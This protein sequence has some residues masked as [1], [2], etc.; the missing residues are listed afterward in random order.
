MP[1]QKSE[2]VVMWYVVLWNLWVKLV[3]ACLRLAYPPEPFH[4]MTWEI[5]NGKLRINGYDY[6][7][8]RRYDS[9]WLVEE[10]CE[11]MMKAIL[12]SGRKIVVTAF[13]IEMPIAVALFQ[14]GVITEA[15]LLTSN[16]V[17]GCLSMWVPLGCYDLHVVIRDYAQQDYYAFCVEVP[18]KGTSRVRDA[19][20]LKRKL[21]TGEI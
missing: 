7:Y 8:G 9:G 21:A 10:I 5:R 4:P 2:Q 11:P 3:E 13:E 1:D 12:D 18:G 14:S 20:V 19:E 16:Q 15:V 17:D 6:V